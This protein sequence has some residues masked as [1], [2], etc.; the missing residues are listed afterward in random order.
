MHHRHSNRVELHPPLALVELEVFQEELLADVA[1]PRVVSLQ[2]GTL[3]PR[4]PEL[5]AG[6][7]VS[8]TDGAMKV[9]VGDAGVEARHW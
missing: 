9:L 5:E 6:L 7:T 3:Q 8:V 4:L 2:S 1:K